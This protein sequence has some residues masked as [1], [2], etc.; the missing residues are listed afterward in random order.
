MLLSIFDILHAQNYPMGGE[1]KM[2][3]KMLDTVSELKNG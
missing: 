1:Q 3:K 2:A